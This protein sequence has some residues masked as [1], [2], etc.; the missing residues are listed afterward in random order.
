MRN[1]RKPSFIKGVAI[2][3][4]CT[5]TSAN[6]LLSPAI[7]QSDE[8]QWWFN[9]EFIAFSRD[10]LPSNNEDFKQADFT[11]S[12]A[13]SIDLLSI[14]SLNKREYENDLLNMLPSCEHKKN[15]DPIGLGHYSA[16]WVTLAMEPHDV[17]LDYSLPLQTDKTPPSEDSP[18]ESDLNSYVQ[19]AENILAEFSVKNVALSCNIPTPVTYID[20]QLLAVTLNKNTRLTRIPESVYSNGEVFKPW[21][22]VID[23]ASVALNDYAESVFKQRDISPLLKTAWRQEVAFGIDNAKYVNIKAGELLSTQLGSHTDP[24]SQYDEQSNSNGETSLTTEQTSAESFFMS[25]EAALIENEDID[26]IALAQQQEAQENQD[27]SVDEQW[28]LDGL[29]KVYLE[30]VN[31]VPYLHIE[32]EFKHHRI[33]M[34]SD[35]TA[36]IDSYP[37][38]QRRRIISKQIHYFDHP[39]F[40]IIVRLERFT[41]PVPEVDL[42][43]LLG[44]Q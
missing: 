38:K 5:F 43:T 25:L 33:S 11:F 15:Y 21:P 14:E 30:Y 42:D 10:L 19:L 40:G 31:Q 9:V 17:S 12:S 22:H 29:F 23:E 36:T 27:T 6:L 35:N 7:A 41:P 39:T 32:S 16:E 18:A 20:E 34:Q 2:T 28:E 37:F 1:S 8:Q 4:C 26:W 3:I 24:V 44:Q 13:P